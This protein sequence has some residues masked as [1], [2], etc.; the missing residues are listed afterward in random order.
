MIRRSRFLPLLLLAAAPLPL[1]PALAAEEAAA[2]APVGADAVAE[3]YAALLARDYVYPETGARYAAAIRAAIAAGR[4]RALSGD[5]LAKAIDEDVNAVAPDG[6]LRVRPPAGSA[7]AAPPPGGGPVRVRTP[8]LPPIEQPGW[9]APGI[10]YIRFNLFPDD[11]AVTAATAKFMA[12]HADARAI[13]FDIRT[14]RGGGLDQMDV[15]FPWLFAQPTRLVTMATRESVD[16][17]GGSPIDGIASMRPVKG[18]AGMV[19]REH[20]ATPNGDTR[21]RDAKIYVLTSGASG[22]A[23]EHF[24][25]AMKHTRRGTLVGDATGGANHFGYGEELGD[26]FQAFIPVG[27]TYDPVTGKDWEG[28]GVAPDVAVPAAEALVRVLTDL[29]IGADEAKRLSDAHVPGAPMER[30]RPRP[31][32][33]PATPGG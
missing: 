14:H 23:A 30:R 17:R 25:L 26:G 11:A 8:N 6:H 22:S 1:T 16:A 12:D 5:A 18:D 4:Y 2:P 33:A 19:A 20:W 13:I 21:L 32:A 24:A 27:R 10:A 28:D 3:A 15:I 7:P 31:A 29:G 9:I